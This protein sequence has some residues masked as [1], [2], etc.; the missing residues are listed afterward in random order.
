MGT[1]QKYDIIDFELGNKVAGAGFP[2]YKG[3]G[4]RMQR[5]L[6]SYFLDKNINAGYTEYQVPLM[7]NELSGFG[8]GQLPDKE[9]QMYH[10]TND[11][12]YLI[13]TAEVPVTNMFRDVMLEEKDL[14]IACTAYTRVS[15]EKPVLM[16][17]MCVGLTVCTSLKK[18]RSFV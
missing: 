15:E 8:T 11:D 4:A 13:P 6:I 16:V 2:I 14:P 9:G 17:R 10:V 3:K 7:V 1:C 18:W 5:A 12:L